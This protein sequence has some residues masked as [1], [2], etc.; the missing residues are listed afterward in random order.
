MFTWLFN[1]VKDK[2]GIET[3]VFTISI[4]C[5]WAGKGIQKNVAISGVEKSAFIIGCKISKTIIPEGEKFEAYWVDSFGL[6]SPENRIFN[7]EDYRKY[8]IEVDF[9]Y[10]QLSQNKIIEMTLEVEDCCPVGKEL[11]SEGI[12]EGIV[13]SNTNENGRR[14]M[15]KSKGVKHQNSKVK[16]LKPVDDAK[17]QK[18]I[19]VVEKV[20]PEWRLEQMLQ[21]TFDLLNGGQIDR[22]KM[23]DYIRKVIND[24]LK[25]ELHVLA[26]ANLEPKDINSQVSFVARKYFFEQE[27]AQA[28]VNSTGN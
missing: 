18:V 21:E 13:F 24:I 2:Y 9:N 27:A 25:E 26:E 7:I 20:T 28:G 11:G 4:F 5:E 12:G 16:T 15:F 10:P 17:I 3:S 6:R 1:Q 23:G 22:L 19:E 14:L 8:E